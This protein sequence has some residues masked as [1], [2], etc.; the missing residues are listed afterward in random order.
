[1]NLLAA[2]DVLSRSATYSSHFDLQC[3]TQQVVAQLRLP[4]MLKSDELDR[5]EITYKSRYHIQLLLF[6]VIISRTGK[7]H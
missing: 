3:K 6:V 4:G 5:S 1:M 2:T 7:P